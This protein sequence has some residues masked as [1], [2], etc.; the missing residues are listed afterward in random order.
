MSLYEL[1]IR[2]R[3]FTAN[4]DKDFA[5]SYAVP[6]ELTGYYDVSVDNGRTFI[7]AIE[8]KLGDAI[9]WV[10]PDD[11]E[12]AHNYGGP[13]DYWQLRRALL[14]KWINGTC[15]TPARNLSSYERACSGFDGGL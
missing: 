11:L 9:S 1:P 3:L 6:I 15:Y 2:L 8:I 4:Q 10:R 7:T 12:E 14:V 13:I 5:A